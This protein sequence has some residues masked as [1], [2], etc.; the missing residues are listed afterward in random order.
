MQTEFHSKNLSF[1]M[2][3]KLVVSYSF[4][5]LFDLY[6]GINYG[7]HIEMFLDKEKFPI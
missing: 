4:Y 7:P 6:W 5:G 3:H 1:N 2:K